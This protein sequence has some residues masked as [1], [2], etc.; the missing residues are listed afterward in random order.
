MNTLSGNIATLSGQTATNTTNIATVSGSLATTNSNLATTNS[1]L[2]TTNSNLSTTNSSLATT[3]TNISTLSGTVATKIG[4]TSLSALGPLTYNNTTGVFSIGQATTGTNGYLSNTDWNTFNSKESV[5]TFNTGLTRVGNTISDLFTASTGIARTGNNFALTSVGTAG[6]YGS[7]TQIPVFTTDT[8]G[9]ITSVTNTA[10]PA[11][12]VASVFG[13]TGAITAQS[14]DYS[15]TQVTEGTNL[16]YTQSRFDTALAAKS[17]TNLTEGTNLYYTNA[18][19]LASPL[20]G[21]IAGAGTVAA[22]DSILQAFQKLQGTNTAQDTTINGKIGLTALSASGPL[23]YNNTTGV[24]SI[25]QST[26]STSGYLSSTD[27]NTF[28]SK[29]SNSLTNGNIWIGNASNIPTAQVLSGD[30]TLSNGGLFTIGVG[31]VTSGK[32]LDG[33]ILFA[34]FA[35]NGC[36]TGEIFKYNGAAWVCGTDTT[37]VTLAIGTLDSVAK[38]ANGAVISGSNLILQTADATNPGI[39]STTSQTFAGNKTF[40]NNVTINGS[41]TLTATTIANIAAGGAI[42]TAAATVDVFTTF[43]VNQTT[44]DQTITLPTPTVTTAGKLAYVNNIG[45]VEFLI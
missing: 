15:T 8:Q 2:A 24:F 39:V 38:S 19:S 27:W 4:L 36:L 23:A 40:S 14:G 10:I 21:Y 28:N 26:A 11:A 9:R 32:I 33:T 6:T 41:Q 42:G 43:N 20:T 16:Y 13:R 17:T 45:T 30:A 3:N 18:R 44:A 1:N 12:L 22:T 31:T 37:G 29:L 5:L 34:D 25:G 35:A 7:A